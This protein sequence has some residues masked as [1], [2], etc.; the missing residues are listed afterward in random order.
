MSIVD[1]E[2]LPRLL[3]GPGAVIV[4]VVIGLLASFG[5]AFQLH[6]SQ[7]RAAHEEF[8]RRQDLSHYILVQGLRTYENA[9]FSLRL[10]AAN[11][12]NFAHEEFLGAARTLHAI[13]PGIQSLQW[14][15]DVR[16]DQLEGFLESARETVRPDFHLHQRTASGQIV[17][18]DP[19]TVPLERELTVISYVYPVAGNEPAFGYDVRTA[20]SVLQNEESRRTGAIVTT[21][22]IPLVEGFRGVVLTAYTPRP[23]A[24]PLFPPPR[25][26]P[27]FAQVVLRLDTV[28]GQI[29]G[30][31]SRNNSDFA[32]YD[33]TDGEPEPLYTRLRQREDPESEPVAF[34]AFV[35][36][37]TS[38]RDLSIGGR[39]WR[40]AY[41]PT[42]GLNAP[43]L[44][45]G[46]LVIFLG[47]LAITGLGAAYL[48]LM[49]RRNE[50]IRAEVA[51]RTA[52][53]N[54][55]RALLEAIIDHNPSAIW[56]KDTD[57][58]YRL[59]NRT[60]AAH[61]G[62]EKTELL[63]VTELGVHTAETLAAMQKVDREV[64][65]DGKTRHYEQSNM[66]SGRE[67]TF[68][69]SKFAIRRRDGTISSVAGVSTEITE[70]RAAEAERL[71]IQRKL[72]ETQ[73]LESLGVL[74]GGIAH[75]FN[76]L[77][78][79]ILGH[80]TLCRNLV[81][82]GS[83]GASSLQQIE[84]AAR[85]AGE[86]C[87]QML[88]YSGRGRFSI[89]PLD[90]GALVG[91]SVPLLRLSLPKSARLTLDL[92]PGLPSVVAD[93]SQVRQIVMNLVMNAAEALPAAGGDITARTRL[94]LADADL[95]AACVLQP[96]LPAGA[97]VCLEVSDTGSGMS[98]ETIAK[99]F[100][101]FYTTKFTG[102]G[103]GLAAVLGIVRGHQGALR[104]ISQPGAGS[105]FF[106]YLPASTAAAP[107][108]AAPFTPSPL[109]AGQRILL[110]EDEATVRET[111]RLILESFGYEVDAAADG[112]EGVACF[113]RDPARPDLAL[114]DLT[115]PGLSGQAVFAALRA[116]RPDLPVLFMSGFSESD[117]GELLSAPRTGFLAKP[118]TLSAL[119][120]KLA[121][122]RRA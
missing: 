83:S 12:T 88:A 32:L 6:R 101:P 102:R 62:R 23:P 87:Q 60:F 10:V 108:S 21:R 4:P 7:Q 31:P 109:P 100:D 39:M 67:R 64:L 55:S 51:N 63:G 69:I 94:V 119:R 95:F 106:L 45:A 42:P 77:L 50:R 26:G 98:A 59:V 46:T 30:P 18:L 16:G 112:L 43:F 91:E 73:K 58:R 76:N 57:L 48:R 27:G 82:P 20:P 111:A 11:N 113:R 54:D 40:A 49:I 107:A 70:L 89:G 66:L 92:A 19:A 118:F 78:T 75:D 14:V 2:K 79:G 121:A 25:R 93:A 28:L 5:A 52:E 47:G 116:E 8:E 15:V 41:R 115:M 68:L 34:D 56:I 81:A 3:R 90:L 36:P 103:L 114:L 120:Q 65:A 24:E 74:A 86:L 122:L 44:N 17:R 53:L 99:I 9:V 61:Y 110:V 13:T 29:L 104:V 35:T 33:L 37:E 117:A 105:S 84:L 97:Y 22:A 85:R 1:N 72:Q 38:L 80:A 71:A 96:A